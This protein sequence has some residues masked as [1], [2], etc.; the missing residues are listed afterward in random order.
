M[1]ANSAAPFE[2]SPLTWTPIGYA[3]QDYRF[4]PGTDKLVFKDAARLNWDDVD[5]RSDHGNTVLSLGGDHIELVGVRP[6]ELTGN[7]FIFLV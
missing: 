7:D 4:D 1:G 3:G 6:Y 5:I 2:P